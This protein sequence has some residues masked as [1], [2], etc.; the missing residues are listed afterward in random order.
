MPEEMNQ[1]DAANLLRR[2]LKKQATEEDLADLH[3]PQPPVDLRS[4]PR[5]QWREHLM[6]AVVLPEDVRAFVEGQQEFT[7]EELDRLEDRI[8]TFYG[9]QEPYYITCETNPAGFTA[10]LGKDA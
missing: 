2:Y 8:A 10:W 7:R 1:D 4:V 6:G 5:E 3:I 9:V